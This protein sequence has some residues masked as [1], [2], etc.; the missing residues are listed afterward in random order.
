MLINGISTLLD[1]QIRILGH[2][3]FLFFSAKCLS[4]T[5][6]MHPISNSEITGHECHPCHYFYL[7]LRHLNYF[8]RHFSL[9]I[10]IYIY[11][12]IYITYT[13][14]SIYTYIYAYRYEFFEDKIY[15][16]LTYCQCKEPYL[17]NWYL[18]NICWVNKLKLRA[19]HCLSKVCECK[20]LSLDWM[21][22]TLC[23]LAYFLNTP[24]NYF[25]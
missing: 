11:R 17:E 22:F 18:I 8:C 19:V 2:C 6:R 21:F 9:Y 10:C 7:G 15:F 25:L 12:Y 20:F 3:C 14:L 13:S 1:A 4:S 16:L 24:L 5:S 23:Y